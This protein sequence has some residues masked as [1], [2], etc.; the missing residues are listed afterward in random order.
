MLFLMPGTTR[1]EYEKYY[2][3]LEGVA[4]YYGNIT[5]EED[6]KW[7]IYH[8]KAMG[9]D[10]ASTEAGDLTNL[11]DAT[12]SAEYTF[13]NLL[14]ADSVLGKEADEEEDWV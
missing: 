7:Y 8:K 6:G 9:Q 12:Y 1:K 5:Y 13:R 3:I 4:E 14:K 10:E 2:P 11:L